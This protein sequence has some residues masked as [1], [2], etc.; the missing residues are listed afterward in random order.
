M[1]VVQLPY[2]FGPDPVGG[3]EVYVANLAR[4]LQN[5]GVD[6]IVAAPDAI[7]RSYRFDDVEVR[8]FAVG[9]P[10]DLSELYGAGNELAAQEF[11]KI[12]DDENPDVVHLH[13]VTAGISLRTVRAAKARGIP[14]VFTYHTPTVSCQRGTLLRWGK[15]ICDGEINVARCAGCVLNSL[16]MPPPLAAAVGMI[17]PAIG[18]NVGKL[19]LQGG[20]WTALRLSELLRIRRDSFRAMMDEVDHV[21]AVSD[22]V[23]DL[24]LRN[25]V[26]ANK[27]S[28]S[29][30]GINF[31]PMSSATSIVETQ[32]VKIAFFG[33]LDPTKG[34]HVLLEAMASIPEAKIRLDVYGISQGHPDYLTK[35]HQLAGNDPRIAFLDP[36]PQS[37]VIDR[38][39]D[40]DFLA[41]PS[42]WM[43]TGPLVAL[44]AFAAGVPIIG[45]DMGGVRELVRHRVDG[46]LI[47]A[48]DSWTETLKLICDDRALTDRLKSGVRPPKHSK[49]VAD[50]MFAI[51][52]ALVGGT[53]RHERAPAE[54]AAPP[55]SLSNLAAQPGE[56]FAISNASYPRRKP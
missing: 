48:N 10:K 14:V 43:E 11:A 17:P 32:I 41:I 18:R 20:V 35:L 12:I 30:Q 44:E 55:T 13:A 50:E 54:G 16:G 4:D 42:Q 52:R 37:E 6:A 25:G 8:R 28:L 34:V 1:K 15:Q 33:R 29:R 39:R 3:T 23:R 38:L 24:L 40:Y 5:I 45:W 49:V 26:P 31:D 9:E 51:Y 56:F 27:L 2:C 21:I 36:I 22:W 19:G 47:N 53:P 46:L 7:T